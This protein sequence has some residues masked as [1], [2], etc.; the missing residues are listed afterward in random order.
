MHVILRE[1]KC[2]QI[3]SQVVRACSERRHEHECMNMAIPDNTPIQNGDG[4]TRQYGEVEE[5]M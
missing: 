3:T 4:Y 2:R 1:V 5:L